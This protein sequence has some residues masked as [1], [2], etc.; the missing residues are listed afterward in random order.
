MGWDLT[1][2][3]SGT[4]CNVSQR[5]AEHMRMAF[6]LAAGCC[7]ENVAASCE[8]EGGS[9]YMRGL[10]LYITE[11]N[12][13]QPTGEWRLIMT[14]AHSLYLS[15]GIRTTILAITRKKRLVEGE[16]APVLEGVTVKHFC[17]AGTSGM[18]YAS[19][20]AMREAKSIVGRHNNTAI[21]VSG[22]NSELMANSFA[23]IPSIPIIVDMHGVIDEWIEYPRQS[24]QHRC[25]LNGTV[26]ALKGIRRR[27]VAASSAIMAVSEP[28]VEYSTASFGKKTAFVIP[29]GLLQ[30]PS[31]DNMQI[32]R[33]KWR[34]RFGLDEELAVAYSGGLSRWQL[35]KETCLL[36][37]T[38]HEYRPDAVL[39]LFTPSPEEALAIATDAGIS[40]NDVI[41]TYLEPS[42]VIPA[43]SAADIGVLLR[44]N[45]TTN[46]VAFPNK[47]AE[48]VAAGLVTVT[49]PGLADPARIVADYDIGLAFP[50]D[51]CQNPNCI[52]SILEM[53]TKREN[54]MEAFRHR[55]HRAIHERMLMPENVKPLAEYLK[56]HW[57]K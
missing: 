16:M 1:Y 26:A 8:R 22:V 46:R 50:P 3:I 52:E 23:G 6:H 36:F 43:L 10:V 4:Y 13:A 29:C 17:Y 53:A 41:A 14:R 40:G 37:L 45:D 32:N 28:L 30:C 38:I 21:I 42:D 44:K 5:S 39:L 24:A 15:A 49:S 19:I 35:V 57:C 55:C 12:V 54:D 47:F 27:A 48:Y 2:R 7:E 9:A 56:N 34:H 25:L 11:R 20:C 31:L 51:Q 18:M 33:Q